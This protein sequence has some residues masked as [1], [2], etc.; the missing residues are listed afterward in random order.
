[1]SEK[2]VMSKQNEPVNQHYI[3][4]FYLRGWQIG[5]GE[6]RVYS[7]MIANKRVVHNKKSPAHICSIKHLYTLFPETPFVNQNSYA[8]E[9]FFSR[10]EHKASAVLKC[11]LGSGVRELGVESK[12]TFSSFILSLEY[13]HRKFVDL[14][15]QE[16]VE[17]SKQTREHLL[18]PSGRYS[19]EVEKQRLDNMRKASALLDV[20]VLA[21]NMVLC[22]I[23]ELVEDDALIRNIASMCWS[24]FE[25]RDDSDDFFVSSDKPL[26]VNCGSGF[27]NENFLITLPLS[28]KKLLIIF[29]NKANYGEAFL[30]KVAAIHNFMLMERSDFIISD[31]AIKDTSYLKNETALESIFKNKV[32]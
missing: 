16:A 14:F 8:I 18:Q 2:T 23:K 4:Q 5:G 32:Q 3:P 21:R 22:R 26:I 28:P 29:D 31:R 19:P 15:S 6:Q 11:I 17:H 1:M 10:I 24:T 7:Y 30:D 13:R 20:D 27:Q 9:H 25:Y 12:Q